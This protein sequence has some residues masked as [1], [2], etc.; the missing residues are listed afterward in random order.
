MA[1]GKKVILFIVEGPSDKVS[2]EN[3]FEQYF[4]DSK[5]KIA[6]LHGDITAKSSTSDIKANL[7]DKITD[8][9]SIEKI[10]FPEDIKRIVHLVDT[11]GAFISSDSVVSGEENIKYTKTQI[12]TNN[13]EGIKE[14]NASKATVL[15]VL[16][17]TQQLNHVEYSIYYFSRNLEHV[18]H[19]ISEDLENEQKKD[20]SES[21]DLKYEDKLEEFISF[22]TDS[23]FAVEGDYKKTWQFI[24]QGTNSLNRYSNIHLLFS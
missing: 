15:K 2:F 4:E 16:A 9:C 14:R 6:V 5:T 17:K 19:N 23:E 20:L 22:I 8:F 10:R 13:V 12:I 1:K 3:I 7:S 11:D 18:L 24:M 21:F